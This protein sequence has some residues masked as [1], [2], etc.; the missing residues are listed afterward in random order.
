MTGA[1]RNNSI[2]IV[3]MACV[4]PG[5][6]DVKTYWRNIE[7]GTDS[8]T[9][10][11]ASRWDPIFFDP[12]SK[13]ADRIYCN[14]GGFI[15]DFATFDPFAHG[16]MP[17]AAEHAEP[18]QLLALR[19]A[20]DAL[21]DAHVNAGPPVDR[22]RVGIIL[23]RGGYITPALT[24]LIQNVRTTQEIIL[25]LEDAVPELSADQ[26][27][28]IKAHL[29]SQVSGFGPD[30]AIGLVPNLAASR[31]AN[32]LDFH[33]PAYTVDAAC[34]SSL[35][36]VDQA[37][38]ELQ[39]GRCDL[40]LAG[41]IHLTHDVT[42]WSVFC[43]LGAMSRTG[44]SRPFDARADGLLIGEGVGI[45]V[46]KRLRDAEQKGDRIYA[47]IRGTGVASDGRNT[48]LMQPSSRGQKL[49]LQLAWQAAR[50]DPTA[51][52]AIGLIE[53]HGTATPT[54]D[55]AELRTLA[56]FF[57]APS[58]SSATIGLGSV[59]SMIG[60]TMPAAGVAGLIKG[61]LAAYHGVLPPS[62]NCEQPHPLLHKTR[63]RLLSKA[64]IWDAKTRRVGVN[65]F[66]FG[67]INAHVL[68]ES[69][70]HASPSFFSSTF[71]STPPG[72]RSRR[73]A[74]EPTQILT[75]AATSVMEMTAMLQRNPAGVGDKPVA[76]NVRLAILEPS[77]GRIAK[78]Q[79]L[80]AQG[81]P[82]KGH[83]GYF[84]TPNASINL[85]G[86]VAFLFP[87]IDGLFAPQI[88]D[89]AHWFDRP[90]PAHA[91]AR[92]LEG[93][94]FGVIEVGRLLDSVLRQLGVIPDAIAGHSIG[95]W[96]GMIASG[97]LAEQDVDAFVASLNPGSLE[98]PGTLFLAA[99]CSAEHADRVIVD[100]P[101]IAIS[102]DNCPHQVIL[103]GRERSIHE[104]EERLRDD[105]VLCQVLPF[106]SGFHSPLF[107][108]FVL[109][110]RQHFAQL[111]LQPATIP[112]WSATTSS[113]YPNDSEAVRALGLRHL[114][115]PVRF[116]EL[117]EALYDSGV[118]VYVQVGCGRLVGFVDD[119]LKG[120]DYFA[121]SANVKQ[122]SGIGQLRHVLAALWT[123]GVDVDLQ[124]IFLPPPSQD[125]AS[126]IEAG[127]AF[128]SGSAMPMKLRL[129]APLLRLD[130]ALAQLTRA[131]TVTSLGQT[132]VV[133][134]LH[135]LAKQLA[136]L[137]NEVV[138]Q[139]DVVTALD[140]AP[141]AIANA[142]QQHQ[143]NTTQTHTIHRTISV[144]TIPELIDH[145]FFPQPD[146]WAGLLD[147]YPVVP[148]T[149]SIT[150]M[151]EA[152]LGTAQGKV[153]VAV[154]DIRA[155][156]WLVVE[157]PLEIAITTKVEPNGWVAVSIDDSVSAR[158]RLATCR[159]DPP[160]SNLAA[161]DKPQDT[162]INA[163]ELYASRWMFHGPAYHGVIDMGPIGNNGING[164]VTVPSG[165]G[166]LMDAAGQL[167]G[168]WIATTSEVDK[169]GLP[170]GIDELSFHGPDPAPGSPLSC[171]VRVVDVGEHEVRANLD[172]CTAD[173]VWCRMRNWREH[174]F[175]TDTK[176]WNVLREPE[177][178]LLCH[179]H[180][181]GYVFYDDRERRVPSRDW[182][183]R[184][185]LSEAEREEM[186]R[187]GP[188]AV[189]GFLHGRIAAK[190]AVRHCLWQQQREPKSLIFPVEIQIAGGNEGLLTATLP[191]HDELHGKQFDEL[192]GI[193]FGEL[194][195]LLAQDNDVA[196]AM[197][198]PYSEATN[199]KVAC[200]MALER[201]NDTVELS[202]LSPHERALLPETS[203][204]AW[205]Q[206]FLVAKRVASATTAAQTT[207][208]TG[209]EIRLR[210]DDALKIGESWFETRQEK[211]YV[212][213][214]YRLCE[215]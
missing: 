22:T 1:D 65:A 120:R 186:V 175:A 69:T 2:A 118:R 153:V 50:L 135:P 49:A 18:D 102:N 125:R 184:R 37:R 212:I 213:A 136:A 57:G 209:L 144:E 77:D 133:S 139:Q 111:N 81:K 40:M 143:R 31:I 86:K 177:K 58:G 112:L 181:D 205:V 98:V 93:M 35:V 15:D 87:G 64:E 190:D 33:G 26:L 152:A 95:E 114:I 126:A 142:R 94:G 167:L 92:D 7:S 105:G 47:V 9:R 173:G 160:L 165:P 5:S 68:L 117:I 10:A 147:R 97:M 170:V 128:V 197:V 198:V 82:W 194:H 178:E 43:Q 99:G 72:P 67:G 36:A 185:Y 96:S 39:S 32:R 201:I 14:R 214:W 70:S 210:R 103:C 157:P 107:A 159:E 176:M 163:T 132:P 45:V 122:R 116:R 203:G 27:G 182:L 172:I 59:K 83:D 188:R 149:L 202:Q 145:C 30:T 53:A 84:F 207:D 180:E 199:T 148:M 192:H 3:G 174:R 4:F 127:D 21:N 17:I 104:A 8:I 151:M 123:E 150:W 183:G 119:T 29:Q 19:V 158:V 215:S 189:R 75:V 204:S 179:A 141:S 71:P 79:E 42:F 60:H 20:Q 23:G 171:Y 124:R 73:A 166:G 38:Q 191:N 16:V 211:D 62:L 108:D 66:G 85:G 46:L 74:L 52:D 28:K 206:R 208:V 134:P 76:G 101:D 51:D 200:R 154:T 54:G 78:A 61:A 106:S 80:V 91:D 48:S 161:L 193:R 138:A 195:V 34:A 12:T 110:H 146:S 169:L 11:P 168:Y 121:I 187:H 113:P 24:R 25:S 100:L 155:T 56:D 137:H 140:A 63:M 156:R 55:L 41:G 164:K 109:P 130:K 89:V 88:A 13:A 115:E 90:V 162:V 129:G 44:M 131:S 196:V 6:P